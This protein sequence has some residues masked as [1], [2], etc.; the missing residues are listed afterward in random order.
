V[1]HSA[2]NHHYSALGSNALLTVNPGDRWL[3]S[4]PLYHVGGLGI[5]Y[6]CFLG[7]GAVVL[8]RPG[9]DLADQIAQD[10]ITHLSLVP[11]QL[12]RLLKHPDLKRLRSSLKVVLLGGAPI[13]PDLLQ[14]AS[15]A[16]LPV[17]PTYGLTEMASQVATG[18]PERPAKLRVLPHREVKIADD[19]AICVRGDTLFLGYVTKDGIA[20]PLDS[21]GWFQTGDTGRIDSRGFLHVRGRKDNMFISGGENVHPEAI[22]AAL[23]GVDGIEVV[24]VVPVEDAEYGHR[25]VAFLRYR[26]DFNLSEAESELSEEAR[27]GF[28]H[29]SLSAELEKTL[30]RFMLPVAYYPW[31]HGYSPAGIKLD[32]SFFR[33]LAA[34][35]HRN[36]Q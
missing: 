31:P 22:E 1:L 32:R 6:R 18:S 9:V 3:L 10:R 34:R 5:L 16:G 27:F 28:D 30:P 2:G 29:H 23:S 11:T 36:K 7:G 21:E 12:R 25:P 4:L 33:D 17:Y 13:P 24:V 8:E 26:A 20:R 15:D 35:L 19:G 14:Q